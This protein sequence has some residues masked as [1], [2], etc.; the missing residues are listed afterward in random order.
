MKRKAQSFKLRQS[1]AQ[2]SVEFETEILL[3]LP[4]NYHHKFHLS[5]E[6]FF[7]YNNGKEIYTHSF[8]KLIYKCV[9]VSYK[10]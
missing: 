5:G 9:L 2:G 7:C 4:T 1:I 6:V 8:K 3:S 10:L